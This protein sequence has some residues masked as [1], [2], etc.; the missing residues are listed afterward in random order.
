M[1]LPQQAVKAPTNNNLQA[2]NCN[3]GIMPASKKYFCLLEVCLDTA[4]VAPQLPEQ[5]VQAYGS[6]LPWILTL[7]VCHVCHSQD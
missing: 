3:E 7:R 2:R 6:A 5:I 4:K 1:E